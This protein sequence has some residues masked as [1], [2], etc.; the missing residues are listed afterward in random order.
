MR[1]C[2]GIL[3]TGSR[4]AFCESFCDTMAALT[5]RLR[6]AKYSLTHTETPWDKKFSSLQGGDRVGVGG[7]G[8]ARRLEIGGAVSFI[9][10]DMSLRI[11]TD[12]CCLPSAIG[13][14]PMVQRETSSLR[15]QRCAPADSK[16]RGL[17]RIPLA[18]GL[19]D[20]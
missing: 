4:T 7:L 8:G 11:H 12:L 13:I 6:Q 5:G 9:H 3:S 15:Y 17:G 1:Y 16:R 19:I 20:L 2:L 14:S 10:K 18:L